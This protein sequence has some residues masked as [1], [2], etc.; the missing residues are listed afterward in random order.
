M[1]R[2]GIE[3]ISS[4]EMAARWGISDRR[5]RVLCEKGQVAGAERD[6]KLWK[7]PVDAVKPVDGRGLRAAGIPLEMRG[8]FAAVEAYVGILGKG[9]ERGAPNK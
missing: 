8:E 4:L 1:K 3:Y 7:I 9:G 5:V 2:C 6:G